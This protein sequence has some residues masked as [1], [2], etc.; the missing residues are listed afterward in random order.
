VQRLTDSYSAGCKCKIKD[1]FQ[2]SVIGFQII[3]NT[4]CKIKRWFSVFGFQ[5]SVKKNARLFNL[6]VGRSV[7]QRKWE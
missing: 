4:R 6:P 2:L 7:G 3:K 5:F 1:G